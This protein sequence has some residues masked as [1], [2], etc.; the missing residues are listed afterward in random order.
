MLL[1]LPDP[2]QAINLVSFVSKL[3]MY[4]ICSGENLSKKSIL[5][6]LFAQLE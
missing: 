4:L 6:A 1:V 2:A 5:D 3:V